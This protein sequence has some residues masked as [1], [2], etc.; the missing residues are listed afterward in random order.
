MRKT[1]YAF[2]ALLVTA[3]STLAVGQH[4][5]PPRDLPPDAPIAEI[6]FNV[7]SY[8][9][10]CLDYGPEPQVS[11]APVFISRCNR[12]FS[13]A[14]WVQEINERH[15]VILRT[16]AKVIGVQ[17]QYR[18]VHGWP[19]E[20]PLDLI[21]L[22]PDG[23]PLELQDEQDPPAWSQVFALDGDS[24]IL[25]A[26]RNRVVQV[27]GR[28]SA[29]R[30]PLVLAKRDLADAE[31][32]TFASTDQSDRR[33]TT[34]FVRVPQEQTLW[35]AILNAGPGTVIEVDPSVSLE[36][37][38]AP[39]E[40][41]L[42]QLHEGVTL[43][44]GRRGILPG[45]EIWTNV[46]GL[47]LLEIVGHD[48]RI[49]GLRLHGP[50]RTMEEV[51]PVGTG[52]LIHDLSVDPDRPPGY[53]RSIVDHNE[54]SGWS[55]AA[56]RVTGQWEERDGDD[57]R[58]WPS[59]R[60]PDNVRITRNLI[61]HNQRAELGYGVHTGEDAYPLI[62]ANVFYLNRHAITSG[63][64]A[65]SGY[66]AL[67]NLVLKDAPD[68]HICCVYEQDFDMHG[69]DPGSHHTGGN[70]GGKV[71]IAQ[72]TF[73]GTNR[74]NF[75]L[76]GIPCYRDTSRGEIIFRDQFRGNVSLQED[77][78][79]IRW[80]FVWY[81]PSDPLHL[82][83]IPAQASP[84][85][86]P[87]EWLVIADNRFS[88]PNPTDHLGVGDFDG[89]GR[90]D[91]FLATGAAWYYSSGG[92][93]AW[94]LLNVQTEP[95]DNLRFGDFDGDGR[96]D[97]FTQRGRDWLVSW[98]GTSPWEKI[99]E[100]DAPMSEFAIGDFDGDGQADIFY[101]NGQ[102][103]YISYSGTGPFTLVQDSSFRVR[104]LGFGDFNWDHKTDVIGAVL[105]EHGQRWWMTANGGPRGVVYGWS[106]LRPAFTSTMDGLIIADFNGDG[107]ADVATRDGRVSYNG[108]TEWRPIGTNSSVVAVGKF[109]DNPGADLLFWN[110]RTIA[111]RSS[112]VDPQINFSPQDMK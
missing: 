103:W 77:D 90:D 111:I 7:V 24:I 21:P 76:R 34:G 57:C 8:G 2:A 70:G 38:W 52:I 48:V 37:V 54:I 29:D 4:I 101:A 3:W 9:G 11:G 50:D 74:R 39:P 25:A 61:H 53:L 30:T 93:A 86:T 100:S 108:R 79:A 1:V 66:R 80:Y 69:T 68:Y 6:A 99:N 35:Y 43:R 15:E 49:T 62:D 75:D 10:K 33:P 19:V 51:S 45:A 65:W 44:G 98:G 58:V 5:P 40:L 82:F 18:S 105:D 96:T 107:I 22:G 36:R 67:Y 55:E 92:A 60:V 27:Q 28:R 94:Q 46:R 23:P 78:D 16:G 56:V 41:G 31:F 63:A 91:L 12:T 42:G 106:Q 20:V 112:G 26:D 95:I 81:W 71:E 102:H 85:D 73:F 104:D 13:Q 72:N 97:V 87:P 64:S 17:R 88:A 47:T 14:V 110:S 89:D 83:P 84:P 32:W 59:S 109:D